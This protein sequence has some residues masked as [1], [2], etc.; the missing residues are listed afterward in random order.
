MLKRRIVQLL[1]VIGMK[2][3]VRMK[4][5]LLSCNVNVLGQTNETYFSTF[6]I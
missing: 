1:Y 3:Q 6:K 5:L 4:F 2:F